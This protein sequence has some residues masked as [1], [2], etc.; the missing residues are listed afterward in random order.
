LGEP[1]QVAGL[2]ELQQLEQARKQATILPKWAVGQREPQ[3]AAP[4]KM[5]QGPRHAHALVAARQGAAAAMGEPKKDQPQ[6]GKALFLSPLAAVEVGATYY[7][8]TRSPKAS[9]SEAKE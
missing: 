7:K 4:Q 1:R 8:T 2:H 6:D 5:P 3:R 9:T